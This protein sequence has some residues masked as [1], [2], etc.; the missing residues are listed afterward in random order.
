MV[1]SMLHDQYQPRIAETFDTRMVTWLRE[2]AEHSGERYT[3]SLSVDALRLA[4]TPAAQQALNDLSYSAD[5]ALAQSA[6]K[7]LQLAAKTEGLS[8]P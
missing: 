5:P 3:R 7:A 4:N 2:A 6:Q 8:I 1:A